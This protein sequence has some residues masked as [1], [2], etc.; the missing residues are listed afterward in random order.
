MPDNGKH[1]KEKSYRFSFRMVVDCDV[2]DSNSN[3]EKN[4]WSISPHETVIFSNQYVAKT[5][6]ISPGRPTYMSMLFTKEEIGDDHYSA[7]S[8]YVRIIYLKRI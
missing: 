8:S 3:L 7:L 2:I 4:N 6:D 5:S 1:V